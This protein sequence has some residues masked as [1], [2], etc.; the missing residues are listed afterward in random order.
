MTHDGQTSSVETYDKGAFLCKLTELQRGLILICTLIHFLQRQ[1]C[2]HT[3]SMVVTQGMV[4]DE[5]IYQNLDPSPKWIV[6]HVR[7]TLSLLAVTSFLTSGNFWHLLITY[8]SSLDPD[9]VNGK[10]FYF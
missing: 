4:V 2:L 10:K 8:A 7:L 3:Q 6:A 9:Q 1:Q 5:G